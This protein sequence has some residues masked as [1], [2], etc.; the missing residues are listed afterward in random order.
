MKVL[1]KEGLLQGDSLTVSGKTLAQNLES[2]PD[3]ALGQK[4]IMP[5]DQPLHPSGPLVILKGNLAPEGAVCKIAGLKNTTHVGP[6]KVFD[7]EDATFDAIMK[8]EVK[9]G[10]V[11]VIR[12]EGVRCWPLPRRSSGKAMARRSD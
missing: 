7:S 1:L 6:A 9:D 8:H 5:M 2:A 3:L 12:Y 4:I 11:V 10:D